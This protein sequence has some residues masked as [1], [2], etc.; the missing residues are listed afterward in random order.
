MWKNLKK[1]ILG[2]FAVPMILLNIFLNAVQSVGR[3][4]EEFLTYVIWISCG[5]LGYSRDVLKK[6][7]NLLKLKNWNRQWLVIL[8]DL[9]LEAAKACLFMLVSLYK[10][11]VGILKTPILLLVSAG[12]WIYNGLVGY[13]RLFKNVG[14]DKIFVSDRY[15]DLGYGS[16]APKKQSIIKRR[17]N[18]NK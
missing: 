2:V 9:F 6:L 1:I 17:N 12:A 7:Y 5:F 3:R 13:V 14:K 10:M 11:L 4:A 15:Q 8:V 16:E 18:K